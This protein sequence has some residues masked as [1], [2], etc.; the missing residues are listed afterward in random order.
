MPAVNRREFVQLSAAALAGTAILGSTRVVR[1]AEPPIRLKKAVKLSMVRVEDASLDDRFK[2][3][4][5]CG[6]E[7]CEI[8]APGTDA[9]QA[10]AAAKKAGIKIHGV[11]DSVHWNKRFSSP[12]KAILEEAHEALK[13]AIDACK[14][15]GGTTVLVVPASLRKGHDEIPMQE[16]W[17]RSIAEIKR[18]VPLAKE[19]GVKIAI[20]TVWNEFITTP[21][22]FVDYIDA[23]NDPT[24]GG[25]FD[26]SNM[27]KYGVSSAEW[28]R[29][30]GQRLLKVDCKG[31]NLE[32]QAFGE[33]GTGSENW[34][35]V[36][37]ALKDVNY[38][39][40]FLTA[41]VRG[42]GKERLLEV[43]QQMDKVLQL[44]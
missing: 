9:G 24:V 2:L 37:Q 11:I 1:A 25:Y 10:L 7:G 39:G 8:D 3:M 16:A 42:G 13:A 19:A 15:V 41:E 23:F 18:G 29:Q 36:L 20:E 17:D 5:D 28:I 14:T 43:S 4:K 6:F 30:T 26:I 21:K 12:D 31:Y 38:T 32:K 22:Q 34:P 27:L 44:T 33:I 35:E 40:E